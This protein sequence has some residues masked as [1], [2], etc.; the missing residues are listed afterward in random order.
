MKSGSQS[1]LEGPHFLVQIGDTLRSEVG[2]W[3]QYRDRAVYYETTPSDDLPG[4]LVSVIA[5]DVVDDI[6]L[7]PAV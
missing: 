5:S 1:S 7:H 4:I 2:K 3:E 6:R